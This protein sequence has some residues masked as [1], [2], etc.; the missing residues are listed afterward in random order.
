M[1]ALKAGKAFEQEPQGEFRET[2]IGKSS[3][4]TSSVIIYSDIDGYG[5]AGCLDRAIGFASKEDSASIEPSLW[6]IVNGVL[7]SSTRENA[8]LVRRERVVCCL[9]N[10]NRPWVSR[11]PFDDWISSK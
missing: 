8:K 5:T 4:P 10:L 2:I 11:S 9:V 3:S 6:A 1:F 7:G